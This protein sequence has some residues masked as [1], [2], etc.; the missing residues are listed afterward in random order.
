MI[1]LRE[2]ISCEIKCIGE[3]RF[4]GAAG[5]GEIIN[6]ALNEIATVKPERLQCFEVGEENNAL[7]STTCSWRRTDVLQNSEH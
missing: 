3:Q 5:C 6:V 2:G 4:H 1:E 7:Q